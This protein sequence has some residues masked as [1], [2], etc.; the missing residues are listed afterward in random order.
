MLGRWSRPS[1]LYLTGGI[2]L[3][4][5]GIVLMHAYLARVAQAAQ[6][7]GPA[8][9]VV[10]VTNDIDRGATLDPKDLQV[11]PM[12]RAYAPPGAFGSIDQAAGRVA[13]ADLSKGEAV[14]TSRLARVRAGPVASLIPEGL[15][16][17]AVPT[18]LPPGAIAPGDRVDVL[19]TY[20]SGQPH[21][22][23]IVQGVEVL[24]V[25]G[26]AAGQAP[27]GGTQ[28]SVGP[29]GSSPFDAGA[30]GLSDAET[31]IL[32]VSPDQEERLAF[33]RAFADLAVAVEPASPPIG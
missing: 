3:A 17:F 2:A 16:A 33:A 22:E 29:A 25:V 31:L 10:V 12:P 6:A 13:L 7:G 4:T 24:Y 14:T 5:V 26:G 18:S 20:S 15:R 21:T 32:L 30:G 28:G 11:V 23:S 1:R 8:V 9:P 27:A 19:A